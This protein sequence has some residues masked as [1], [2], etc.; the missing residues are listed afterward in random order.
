MPRTVPVSFHDIHPCTPA[1]HPVMSGFF[2]EGK[3]YLAISSIECFEEEK[4]G[5]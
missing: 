1:G 3:T 4:K 5:K 2:K